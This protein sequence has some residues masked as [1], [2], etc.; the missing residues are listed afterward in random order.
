MAVFEAIATTYLESTQASV[1]FSS[2][3]TTYEHL[4]LRISSRMDHP[5]ASGGAL[6]LRFNGDTGSNY[7]NHTF[8]TYSGTSLNADGYASFAYVYQ[9]GRNTGPNSHASIYAATIIDI[10][11]YRNTNKNTTMMG[12]TES[13][14]SANYLSFFSALWDN[15]AAVTS[16]LLFPASNNGDFV[17][18]T[19]MTLYGL[20][21]AN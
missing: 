18:D 6:Q 8:Q 12:M 2:I 13:I 15:T 9:A 5:G 10:L 17:A 14:S 7:S 11:D 3:P 21:S 20:N 16:I 4:Q 19:T 1:T